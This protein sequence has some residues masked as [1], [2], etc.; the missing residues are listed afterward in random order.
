MPPHFRIVHFPRSGHGM[1]EEMEQKRA[2]DQVDPHAGD[3]VDQIRVPGR[4]FREEPALDKVP[5]AKHK[6]LPRKKQQP[7]KHE[8]GKAVFGQQERQDHVDQQETETHDRRPLCR[9]RGPGQIDTVKN[10][11]EYSGNR[12]LHWNSITEEDTEPA[13]GKPVPR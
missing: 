8:H 12:Q 2:G 9:R 1:P 4:K 11:A 13:T 5:V 3:I 10:P 7:C 6:E